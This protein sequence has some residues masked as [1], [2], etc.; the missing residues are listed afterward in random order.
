MKVRFWGVRGSIPTPLTPQQVKS[1][2][3]AVIQRVRTSDLE[4]PETRE[5]FLAS[6]P[7]DLFGTVG[8]NT[9]CVELR[10]DSGALFILDAGTGI[11]E[12]GLSLVREKS[13]ISEFNI[14]WSHFHWDHIQGLPFFG[15]A[16]NPRNRIRFMSPVADFERVL[17]EQMRP[18][19]FPVSLEVMGCEKVFRVLSSSPFELGGVEIRFRAMNHPGGAYAYSFQEGGRKIIYATD[20]ELGEDDF[21]KSP[22]NA[23]FFEGADLI[24]IDSQYTLGEAIE[25]YNWGHSSFSMAVDFAVNWGIKN[26]VLFHHEPNYPDHRIRTIFNEAEWYLD[27]VDSGG[28]RIYLALEGLELSF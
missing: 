21:L 16:F 23:E 1:K 13:D 28:I 22:E 24:I 11:R 20:T 18:P 19:Y 6:L 7:A 15:P 25:K 26:L 10:S 12:L 8:G 5:R 4:T 3:S 14:L 9:P 17:S 2:I 27:H